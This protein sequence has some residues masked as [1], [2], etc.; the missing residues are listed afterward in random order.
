MSSF[1]QQPMFRGDELDDLTHVW[2]ARSPDHCHIWWAD[3]N[4]AADPYVP[5]P[6]PFPPKDHPEGLWDDPDFEGVIGELG[7]SAYELYIEE[8]VELPEGIV[9]YHDPQVGVGMLWALFDPAK[10]IKPTA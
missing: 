7:G 2:W 9:F 8:E 5:A 3:R 10:E 6:W 4:G 1:D